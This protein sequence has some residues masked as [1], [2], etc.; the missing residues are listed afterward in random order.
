MLR[1]F[2]RSTKVWLI[3]LNFSYKIVIIRKSLYACQNEVRLVFKEYLSHFLL[4]F[5]SNKN[6]K[7]V[8]YD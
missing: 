4:K 8:G 5:Y 3:S 1:Y 7:T 6:C 2:E